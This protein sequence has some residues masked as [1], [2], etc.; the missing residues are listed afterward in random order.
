[1]Y[2]VESATVSSSEDVTCLVQTDSTL[3]IYNLCNFFLSENVI[4][5]F[6]T[7]HTG[8]SHHSLSQLNNFQ[9]ISAFLW[10][11]MFVFAVLNLK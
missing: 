8:V 6:Q 3:K 10:K 5:A 1:M 11:K 4:T 7:V 2:N 9:P